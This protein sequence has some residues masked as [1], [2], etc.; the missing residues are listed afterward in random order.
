MPKLIEPTTRLHHAWLDARDEWGRGVHQDGSGL[1]PTDDVDS[2]DGFAAWVARLLAEA[3]VTRPAEP[4]WVHCTYRWMVE[5]DR[6]LGTISLR[7]ELNAL[8]FE[9]GGHIGYGVRPA[10]RGRGL[11]GWALAEMLVAAR[12]LGLDRVLITCDD[13]NAASA[14]TIERAGG[15]RE[16]IR[17]HDGRRYR[18]YWVSTCSPAGVS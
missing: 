16:D 12:A 5:G 3:D 2:A 18:R 7:H 6:V 4:G 14:R 1:R 15:V 17:E 8:L 11:A 9:V 13:T 10:E